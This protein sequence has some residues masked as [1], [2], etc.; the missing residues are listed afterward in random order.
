MPNHDVFAA[1]ADPTRR[2]I[3]REVSERGSAT[4][5]E[6]A[7]P[8]GTER[9]KLQREW[10]EEKFGLLV[11]HDERPAGWSHRRCSESGKAAPGHADAW[12]PVGPDRLERAPQDSLEAARE[13][14]EAPRL[15]VSAARLDRLDGEALLLEPAQDALPFLL[16]PRR[17]LLDELELRTGRERFR[18]PHPRMDAVALG[19]V[20]TGAEERLLAG[21]RCE[22]DR[23]PVKL[24]ASRERCAKSEGWNRKAND[25]GN[26]CSTR[27]HVPLSSKR[28]ISQR[29]ASR[30]FQS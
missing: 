27:T 21:H 16:R 18:E 9:Q 17:I 29:V 28:Q 5:T 19:D 26:V 12:F 11:V 4:A 10:L 1:L 8:L 3:M 25:H 2:T 15:E 23:P 6:L 20:V 7:P 13:A 24:G 30:A 14:F 22:R